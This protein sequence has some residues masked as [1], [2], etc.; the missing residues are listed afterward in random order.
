MFVSE[1]KNKKNYQQDLALDKVIDFAILNIVPKG[2]FSAF[3]RKPK[4]EYSF[5]LRS[6]HL[7]IVNLAAFL[8]FCGRQRFF[9]YM[10]KC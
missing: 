1:Q 4:Q 9:V 10:L 2:T 8:R 3:A 7:K 5:G 6:L